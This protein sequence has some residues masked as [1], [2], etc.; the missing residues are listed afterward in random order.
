M[1][2]AGLYF[3]FPDGFMHQTLLDDDVEHAVPLSQIIYDL[4]CLL[5]TSP[6]PRDRG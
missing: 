6:S 4:T 3:L 1:M 2:D 5:Y